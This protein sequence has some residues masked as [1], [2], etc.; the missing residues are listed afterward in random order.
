MRALTGEVVIHYID[1]YK[2]DNSARVKLVHLRFEV[3][4]SMEQKNNVLY[5]N[6]ETTF[7]TDIF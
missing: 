1:I 3:K 2:L 4:Q 6:E 7:K 5:L